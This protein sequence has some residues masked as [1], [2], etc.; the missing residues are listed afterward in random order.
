MVH[1]FN[2]TFARFPLGKNIGAN[3]LLLLGKVFL[4]AWEINSLDFDA[5]ADFYQA[6]IQHFGENRYHPLFT[7]LFAHF[8]L[9]IDFIG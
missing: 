8:S 7:S 6:I 2:Y 9:V 5:P 1:L 3:I 4:C